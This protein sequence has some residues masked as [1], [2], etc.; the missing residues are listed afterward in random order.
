MRSAIWPISIPPA[1]IGCSSDKPVSVKGSATMNASVQGLRIAFLIITL[2]FSA[3]PYS[4]TPRVQFS[5]LNTTLNSVT[6]RR[7]RLSDSSI[8]PA[9]TSQYLTAISESGIPRN[10]QLENIAEKDAADFAPLLGQRNKK[11]CNALCGYYRKSL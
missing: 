11:E 9:K 6:Y 5:R 10:P 3:A 4:A 7:M 2:F 1:F 8:V